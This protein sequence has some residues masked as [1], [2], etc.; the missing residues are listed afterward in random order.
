MRKAILGTF[1]AVGMSFVG[2]SDGE[3]ANLVKDADP[4][5]IKAYM[6]MQE[7]AKQAMEEGAQMEA[8][9][10]K[11]M[12]VEARKGPPKEKEE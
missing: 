5:D 1:I 10:M 11:D 9:A 8:Q 7:K 2:C 4:Q 12:S 3:P 6:E